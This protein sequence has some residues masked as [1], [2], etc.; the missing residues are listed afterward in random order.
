[1]IPS[2]SQNAELAWKLIKALSATGV[3]EELTKQVGIALSR[4]SWADSDVVKDDPVL[5]VVAEARAKAVVPDRPFWTNENM[6]KVADAGKT[7][8]EN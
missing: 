8:Y 6:A 1:M 7:M 5:S 3:Q 2:K 4:R